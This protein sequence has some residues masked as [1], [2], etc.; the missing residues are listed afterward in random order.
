MRPRAGGLEY[1][2]TVAQWHA[3]R[4]ARRSKVT[5]LAGNA[6]LR[7]YVERQ[8]RIQALCRNA[9]RKGASQTSR[10]LRQSSDVASLIK[11]WLPVNQGDPSWKS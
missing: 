1:R 4:S 2:A 5:K 9:P 8:A 3:K 10:S 6:A 11:S 7:S